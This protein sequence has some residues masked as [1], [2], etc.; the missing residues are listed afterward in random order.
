MNSCAYGVCNQGI[1]NRPYVYSSPTIRNWA[2]GEGIE[3]EFD[4]TRNTTDCLGQISNPAL[5]GHQLDNWDRTKNMARFFAKHI[6][7]TDC[8]TTAISPVH[9]ASDI[10]IYPNPPNGSIKFNSNELI[11]SIQS[12]NVQG[13]KIEDFI[14]IKQKQFTISTLHWPKGIYV[15]ELTTKHAV[16]SKKIVVQ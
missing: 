13:T 10:S 12:Y 2:K 4:S 15:I 1:V 14:G 5:G 9:A 16:Q 11:S 7:T 3:F 6:D 8:I